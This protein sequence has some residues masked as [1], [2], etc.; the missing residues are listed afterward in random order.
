[1]FGS[2]CGFPLGDFSPWVSGSEGHQCQL[3]WKQMLS[4]GP[5]LA[6]LTGPCAGPAARTPRETQTL[7][8]W[9][10]ES[11]VGTQL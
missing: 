4:P 9:C 11:G 7:L 8:V 3:L 5:G 2:R 10:C 1:M 6:H